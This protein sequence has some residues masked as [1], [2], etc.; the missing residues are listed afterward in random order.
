[1]PPCAKYQG[2]DGE[3]DG[4]PGTPRRWGRSPFQ[5]SH[6]RKERDRVLSWIS[7]RLELYWKVEGRAMGQE[8]RRAEARLWESFKA[9]KVYSK[10]KEEFLKGLNKGGAGQDLHFG[11]TALS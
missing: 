3:Q 1:M 6:V 2:Y 9:F 4:Q 8:E 10:G 7:K 11:K 5:Y